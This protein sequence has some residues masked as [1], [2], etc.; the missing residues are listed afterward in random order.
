[1]VDSK[2]TVY[3]CIISSEGLLSLPSLCTTFGMA[4]VFV[5]S[6]FSTSCT[7]IGIGIEIIPN[8]WVIMLLGTQ[9]HAEVG[10]SPVNARIWNAKDRCILPIV[11]WP[12]IDSGTNRIAISNS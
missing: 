10:N 11:C 1:M 6:A 2:G 12:S 5:P 8:L 9:Q 3:A 4:S 7:I